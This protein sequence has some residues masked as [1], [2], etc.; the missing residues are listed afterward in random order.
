M[1]MN[2]KSVVIIGAGMGGLAAGI[3]GQ[4]NGFKT[5]IFEMHRVPGGQCAAWKRNGYTFDACIHHLFGCDP[6]FRVYRLWEELGAMPRDLIPVEDCV[7]VLSPD[8]RLFKDYYDLER[9]KEHLMTLAPND[10]AVIEH[11]LNGIKICM[12]RDIFGDMTF[13]GLKGV[14]RSIPMLWQLRSYLKPK[15]GQ[16]AERFTDPL[17]RQGFPLVEYSFP[18]APLLLHLV[19]HA[20]GAQGGIAWPASGA[21][22][23][24]KSIEQRYIDLGGQVHYKHKVVKILTD[25][26]KATG[27]V[28]DDGTEYRADYVI[29]DADGRKTICEL[30]GGRFIDDKIRKYIEEPDDETNWAVHV[31]LG[32]NRDLSNEPSSLVMLLDEP[33]VIAGHTCHSIDMQ[34]YGF[35]PS[36]SPAGKGVIKVE[37]FSKY[38][39]WKQLAEDRQRYEEEKQR[40]ADQVIDLLERQHFPGLRSQVEAVDVPTLLT[41]ERFMGGTHGFANMPKKPFNFVKSLSGRGLDITLPSLTRF[42]FVGVWA[43]SAGALFMNA[44]SGRKVMEIICKEE[45]KPFTSPHRL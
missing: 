44:L 4:L 10:R 19:K 8:G 24:A 16:Y 23:F 41:W 31:F 26:N 32:V 13:D 6:R 25:G 2:E 40:V 34:M 5:E 29:S 3:Y 12:K 14:V 18:E 15:L 22:A 36:M 17:L 33:V 30:L 11:Y 43:T 28:L 39:Y 37:L 9:L 35:D 1:S 7:S 21:E 42:Y 45:G 27:V 20:Y 38:S